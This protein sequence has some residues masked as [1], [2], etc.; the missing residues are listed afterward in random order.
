MTPADW[1]DALRALDPQSLAPEP[2]ETD[3]PDQETAPAPLPML[4]IEVDRK[5]AGKIATIISGFEP[6][7]PRAD[8]LAG[9]LKR[10]LAAGGSVRDGE[11]LIQGDRRMRLT[12]ILRALGYKVKVIG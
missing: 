10:K 11:I 8:E 5:R 12:E 4:R 9:T 1:R 2:E 6:D 7:D 3:A